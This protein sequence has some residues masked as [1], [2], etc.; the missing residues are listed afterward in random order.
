MKG[1]IFHGLNFYMT[2][3]RLESLAQ[4]WVW[5][6]TAVSPGHQEFNE[7]EI[8]PLGVLTEVDFASPDE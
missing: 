8:Q 4:P 3:I 7:G 5:C 2:A 1:S 6:V